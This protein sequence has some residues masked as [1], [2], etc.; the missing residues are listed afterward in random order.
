MPRI[1]MSSKQ[2]IKQGTQRR[3]LR[4][5]YKKADQDEQDNKRPKPE[6]TAIS[7]KGKKLE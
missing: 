6:L 1:Y 4:N 3:R 7:Q 2:G 5:H